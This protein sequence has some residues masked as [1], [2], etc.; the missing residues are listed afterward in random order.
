MDVGLSPRYPTACS[1]FYL[2]MVELLPEYIG[3]Q[4]GVVESVYVDGIDGRY[5]E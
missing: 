2:P 5:G 1:L 4:L 3:V